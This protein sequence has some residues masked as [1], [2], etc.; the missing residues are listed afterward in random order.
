MVSITIDEEKIQEMAQAL[1]QE[2][3]PWDDWVWLFAKAELQIRSAIVLSNRY[4]EG[5][6]A[7]Q[8]EIDPD[9]LVDQPSEAE[10]DAL[11]G[12]ISQQSPSLQ[13]LYWFI[14]ERRYIYDQAR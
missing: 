9:L 10:I 3:K 2:Q 6:E 14:A 12:E 11:A 4:Q 1:A 13:D 7:R 8:V 5:G